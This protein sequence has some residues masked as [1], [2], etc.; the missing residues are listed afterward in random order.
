MLAYDIRG[1]G[2]GLVLLPGIGSTAAGTWGTVVDGLAAEH[3]VLL[4][5][6]PGSGSSPL[7][8][9]PLE[10]SAVADQV[11]ATAQEA[12]LDDFVVAG[13]SLG[14]AVAVRIAALRP[15]RV[16][17]LVTLAGFAR[18]RTTLWLHLEMWAS[19]RARHD[20]DARAFLTARSFSEEHLPARSTASAAGTSAQIG[21]A[22]G[23]DVRGDLPAIPVPALVVA[24]VADRFVA[25]E[26]SVELAVGLPGARL[27]AVD[28]GH[29]A[30]LEQPGRTLRLL[31]DFL[32]EI[33]R[34]DPVVPRT[35]AVRQPSGPTSTRWRRCH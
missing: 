34:S 26:H 4:P 27:A 24:A 18:P 11:V 16:R 19:L 17:G 1:E 3:T 5:D 10:V 14:A 6:L 13:A 31:T 12:G 21:L 9:G 15:D 7:P 25:P 30:A 28:A 2:P 32:G 20:G 29:L 33:R 35:G 23:I 22:L 8:G